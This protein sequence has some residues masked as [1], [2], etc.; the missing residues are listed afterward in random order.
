MKKLILAVITGLLLAAAP[1]NAQEWTEPVNISNMGGYCMYPD[2]VIDHNG[3][4]HVVWDYMIDYWYRKILYTSSADYGE[5]WTE[6]LDLLQ[7]TDLWM[8]KPHIDCDS[9]NNLYVT[10]DYATGHVDKMVYMIVYDGHQWSEPILV[11]EEMPGSHYNKILIDNNDWVLLGWYN[12]GK[13]YYRFYFS[14]NFSEIYCP[15]CNEEDKFLPVEGAFGP[16]Q[17]IHWIGSSASFNYYG[18]RL[19]YYLFDIGTNSW[20]EPKMLVE[21]TITVGKDITINNDGEPYCVYRT[22]PASSDKTKYLRREGTLWSNPELVADV[23]AYQQYQQIEVDQNNE[24]HIIEQQYTV[25]S[26]DLVHYKKKEDN[27][28]G[29][30]VDTGL[31]LLF[32]NLTFNNNR[33]FCVYC[34][35]WEVGTEVFSDL[36]FTKYDIITNIEE[37]EDQSEELKIFPNPATHNIYIEFENKKE[38]N[39]N[40]SIYDLTGKDITTLINKKIPR[41]EQRIQWNGTDINGKEVNSGPY[42]VRL[43]SGRKT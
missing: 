2:M 39:V 36:F 33:L 27:W 8:S 38:Q 37:N 16:N 1:L 17:E 20:S 32:P 34:K 31:F 42:L 3:V 7:N 26:Q 19:Q 43:K 11:S 15:Y 14:F 23:S 25:E 40:L 41:G 13:F 6:P 35:G 21:D 29:Q 28:I 12:F 4:I 10:Y 22:Y 30:D 5:T 18:E 9:K 24:V